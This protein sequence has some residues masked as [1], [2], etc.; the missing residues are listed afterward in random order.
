MWHAHAG[1]L[2]E[3]VEFIE[4]APPHF[5]NPGTERC[6]D[7][8]GVAGKC[9]HGWGGWEIKT[10]LPPENYPPRVTVFYGRR[11]K[12]L[13]DLPRRYKLRSYVDPFD[14]ERLS[15]GRT[16]PPDPLEKSERVQQTPLANDNPWGKTNKPTINIALPHLLSSLHL[17]SRWVSE[18][19]FK[20]HTVSGFFGMNMQRNQKRLRKH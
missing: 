6:K 12:N 13:A 14:V 11:R 15:L 2:V 10:P 3:E 5:A 18:N 8:R 17:A 1:A 20:N 9:A 16:P 7:T 4:F 19:H